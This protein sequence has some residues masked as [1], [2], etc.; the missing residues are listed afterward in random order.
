MSDCPFM[1]G[2]RVVS[3]AIPPDLDPQQHRI[4]SAGTVTDVVEWNGD[5][6]VYVRF[7]NDDHWYLHPHQLKHE[8]SIS[9]EEA[10][11]GLSEILGPRKGFKVTPEQTRRI[12]ARAAAVDLTSPLNGGT[13]ECSYIEEDDEGN[14]WPG[15]SIVMPDGTK[16]LVVF[17]RDP[18][19]NGPGH[20]FIEAR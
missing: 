11:A 8:I 2:D 5:M 15:L 13:I 17:S 18:E 20:I 7:D 14:F 3:T 10:L 9:P 6:E 12:A 4:G 19:G 16:R 1:V